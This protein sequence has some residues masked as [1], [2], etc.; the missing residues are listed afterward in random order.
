MNPT[1]ADPILLVEHYPHDVLLIRRAFTKARVPNPLNVVGDGEK[2]INYL[3]GAGEYSDRAHHPL[4]LFILLDLK[5]PRRSG[6]EVLR[7]GRS[8][9]CGGSPWSCPP[10][11]PSPPTWSGATTPG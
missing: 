4:P 3:A 2:A 7:F 9:C 5:L 11:P 8:R 1:D 6:Q 10:V